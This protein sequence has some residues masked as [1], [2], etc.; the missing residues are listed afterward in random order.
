[1][2]SLIKGGLVTAALAAALTVGLTQCSA[3]DQ[4]D[5]AA[6]ASS[7]NKYGSYLAGRYAA[8]ERDS[9]AAAHYF[10]KALKFDPGNAELLERA[11]MSEVAEGDLDAAADHADD[12]I[13]GTPTA[14][15]AH[16]IIG[17]RAMRDGGYAKARAEFEQVSGNAAAEIAARLG[18]AYSHFSEG[19]STE[20]IAVIGKLVDLGSVRAFAL[21][22]QAVIETCPASRT[23][24][25]C[26]SRKRTASPKAT[27]CASCR[28]TPYTSRAT[29]RWT[30]PK[31]ST[32]TS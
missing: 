30:R 28:P 31:A 20:A 25:C 22:H 19:K 27:R 2:T 10:D 6:Q 7:S 14:R 1:M 15:I 12:L 23:K 21:Y 32:A 5:D 18:L 4:Q 13:K 26:I 11:V 16:L 24:R 8:S 9:S 29:A 17:V 3:I